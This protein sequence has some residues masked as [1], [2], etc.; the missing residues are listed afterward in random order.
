[1]HQ[2]LY[3]KWRP[4]DFDEVSGQ[5]HVTSILKY[6]CA[7]GKFSH[8]Y[9]FCGSR[10]TGKT[11][12]AKILAKAVN[13]EHPTAAGPCGECA[14]CRS[15]D[16]GSATDVL[17][18][19]A[20]SNNGVDD[21]RDI[22]D[23][24]I[25][26]PS[27]LKYRVYIIDE[28]HMLSTSAFNALLKTLEEPP[29]HVV[30]ILATT[31][32]QKLPATIISR[33]QRFDFRRISTADL[34]ARLHLIAREENIELDAEA[35][36]LIA[37]QA[38]GGM[39]DAVSLLELCAGARL[40]VTTELVTRTVG[41][42]GREGI[43]RVILAIAEKNFDV[44]FEAVD[45][46]VASSRDLAVFWQEIIGYYRDMLVAKTVKDPSRYLDLTDSEHTALVAAAAR[47]TKEA[48]LFHIGL[49][50]DALFAMQKSYAVKRTVAEIT[51]VRLCD[52]ALDTSVESILTRLSRVEEQLLTGDIAGVHAGAHAGVP[53]QAASAPAQAAMPMDEPVMEMPPMEE[54]PPDMWEPP[55]D[56]LAP[57]APVQPPPQREAPP[58]KP[59]AT[60]AASPAPVVKPT[61]VSVAAEKKRVLRPL[62]T[63]TEAVDRVRDTSRM[64]ASF[65]VSAKA[66][67]TEEGQVVVKL[68]SDFV[69]SMVSREGAPEALRAA[70]SV[71]LGRRLESSDILY[72]VESVAKHDGSLID[73]ILEAAEE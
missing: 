24:V 35:A 33:C 9:L 68:D 43:A 71:C 37:R 56:M 28:V 11:S 27:E 3:R 25:Y 18:M 65:L 72:E 41:T 22:R 66:Y 1:M 14:A 52:P 46:M 21:I 60:V 45:E 17:E 49:L 73:L 40:P 48:M 16:A 51:L 5:D 8:A 20:A 39:R 29:E 53:V 67:T 23:E 42:T 55:V 7:T 61:P 54:P 19:D 62:K 63:W 6:Q 13:C 44:L 50:E 57:T 34:C 32:L 2:A 12:C 26:A 70:L 58:P 4:R 64:A 47:F 10:G 38:Q 15:I 59:A 69:R 31:E 36:R 30:F